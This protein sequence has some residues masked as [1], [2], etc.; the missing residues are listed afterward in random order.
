MLCLFV[1]LSYELLAF[2]SS[3]F[4]FH[5]RSTLPVVVL[6]A[7]S[8]Y[9]YKS[10]FDSRARRTTQRQ[11]RVESSKRTLLRELASVFL[12]ERAN[13]LCNQTQ[14]ARRDGARWVRQVALAAASQCSR[15]QRL[16]QHRAEINCSTRCAKTLD[17]EK[18]SKKTI[19][20]F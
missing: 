11:L 18:K 8:Y 7:S 3:L 4:A 19:Y 20:S 2:A 6:I 10:S 9:Y 13:Y 17:C 16:W 12:H 15:R 5:K 14:R 1:C